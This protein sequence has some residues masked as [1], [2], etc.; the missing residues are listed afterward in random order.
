MKEISSNK[1]VSIGNH[2]SDQSNLVNLEKKE[3]KNKIKKA[4]EVI[5][6]NI[7]FSNKSFSFPYSNNSKVHGNV[8]KSLSFNYSISTNFENYKLDNRNKKKF[9]K[10]D[11]V[12]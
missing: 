2:T 6:T 5:I 9:I 3:I 1:Y 7:G 8:L 4:E 10:K 12:L 11:I